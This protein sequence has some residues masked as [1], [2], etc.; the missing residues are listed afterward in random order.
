MN[1]M[2]HLCAGLH[3][4]LLLAGMV[5][6]AAARG[7]V[8]TA[9]VPEA[10]AS[11]PAPAWQ[12]AL[13]SLTSLRSG[14]FLPGDLVQAGSQY[15]PA[16]AGRVSISSGGAGS[17][18]LFDPDFD[19][20]QSGSALEPAWALYQ[21]T[22]DGFTGPAQ[23]SLD[24]EA[25]GLPADLW[26]ALGDW[27]TA[28]WRFIKPGATAQ[29]SFA[30][31][32]LTPLLE[33]GT[34]R[35]ACAVLTTGQ[36]DW[37]LDELRFAGGSVNY[38]NADCPLGV[39]LEGMADWMTSRV[40]VDA[41]KTAR[42]WFSQ[43]SDSSVWDDGRSIPLDADGYPTSLLPD[44]Y[45]STVLLTEQGG[46]YPSG[47]YICLYDGEGDINFRIDAGIVSQTPGRIV[48]QVNPSAGGTTQL[49]IRSTNPADHIRNI[50]LLLPG[51]EQ[52]H[53]AQVFTPE[54]LASCAPFK[55][56]RFMDWMTSNGSTLTEWSGRTT[57]HSFTQA[58]STGVAVEHMVDLSNRL[59]ADPWF[60]MGHLMSDD[61]VRQF[62]TYVRDNLDPQLRIYIEHSN[63]VWNGSFPQAQYAQQQGLAQGLSNDAYQAQLRYQAKRSVEIFAIW[64]DV[65]GGTDRL[66]RVI[67]GQAVNTYATEQILGY[68]DS[69]AHADAF[70]I[71]PYFG[72]TVD[73]AGATG[74]KAGGI[75]GITA[76]WADI[77]ASQN[78]DY[79]N[80]QKALCDSAGLKLIAYEGGQHLVGV[81]N[82]VNDDALTAL[83][84]SANRGP[85]LRQL[86][87]D[88]LNNW[89][90]VSGGGVMCAFSHIG[91][92][93][94]WGSWG[95]REN[96]AQDPAAAPKWQGCLDFLAAH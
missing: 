9:P 35:L 72:F 70:A 37:Q 87:V 63:E 4:V 38:P 78:T 20:A 56:L 68:A 65:F 50:R 90:S 17:A 89:H 55:V 16:H 39:N 44:Q 52:D 48:V 22:L 57:P 86:Y 67:G 71:A 36:A 27:N 1:T 69:P 23:L 45:A 66:V 26:V 29:L 41:M 18:A 30:A 11:R 60:C 53:A 84:T 79:L 85:A 96:Q 28:R 7:D 58:G 19:K 92:Y 43:P 91:R 76:Q 61:C 42:W 13:P 51:H 25:K 6:C 8:A 14:S 5:G 54:F 62:A 32:D 12:A 10:G 47:Q 2:L 33:P 74:V 49:Q 95:M 59:G 80:A 46:N 15:D 40:W 31:A 81:G 21:F 93:S 88:Y 3:C 73:E 83:L 34:G 94:K 82:A 77:I 24:F 64:E 75:S